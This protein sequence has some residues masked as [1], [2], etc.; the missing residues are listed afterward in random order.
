MRRL[1]ANILR[2]WLALAVMTAAGVAYGYSEYRQQQSDARAALLTG[3]DPGLAV[4]LLRRHG[5]AGC[6]AIKGVEAPGGSVGPPLD[7]I[8]KRLYVGGVLANTP[9]NLVRW[10]V[11]PKAFNPRTAMPV[12]GITEAEARHVA[13]YLYARR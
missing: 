2:L 8:G 9:D 1:R 6:H 7:D 3:G 12:T 10:I 13:A 11:D 5:C 4:P